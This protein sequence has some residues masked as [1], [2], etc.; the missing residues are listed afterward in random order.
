MSTILLNR[1]SVNKKKE[2]VGLP[3]ATQI[4]NNNTGKVNISFFSKI[5]FIIKKTMRMYIPIVNDCGEKCSILVYTRDIN[6]ITGMI[7]KGLAI[8]VLLIRYINRG[9]INPINN[10]HILNSTNGFSP[11]IK[12]NIAISMNANG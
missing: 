10:S 9:M 5:D 3:K 7:D 6:T 11:F 8:R 1:N 2:F 12:A 4:I